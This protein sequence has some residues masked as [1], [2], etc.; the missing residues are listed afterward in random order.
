MS[1]NHNSASWPVIFRGECSRN[2]IEIWCRPMGL[3]RTPFSQ[4]RNEAGESNLSKFSS[5]FIHWPPKHSRQHLVHHVTINCILCICSFGSVLSLV[6]VLCLHL[7]FAHFQDESLWDWIYWRYEM[8][9]HMTTQAGTTTG[10]QLM[11]RPLSI[12]DTNLCRQ[13]WSSQL[14]SYVIIIIFF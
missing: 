1:W 9:I 13:M 3:Q 14:Q 6:N 4:L 12:S 8:C 2:Q 5:N 7:T 10:S 11:E